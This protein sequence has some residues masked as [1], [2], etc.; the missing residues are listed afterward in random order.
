[1][2]HGCHQRYNGAPVVPKPPITD[3]AALLDYYHA[4]QR[5]D[6]W[7]GGSYPGAAPFYE[8]TSVLAGMQE[9][10]A[11]GYWDNYFWVGAG[12]GDVEGDIVETI[13]WVGTIVFGLPFLRSM[14]TPRPSGLLEVDWSSGVAGGH[15]LAENGLWLKTQLRGEPNVGPI[16]WLPQ[17]WGLEHGVARHGQA[18]GFVAIRLRDLCDLMEHGGEGAVPVE[19]RRM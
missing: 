1:M 12:S 9:G 13:G 7:E 16:A 5:R 3:T 15:C 4:C 11:R 19:K 10:Q 2:A 14:F 6:I 18:G 8:G 17:S